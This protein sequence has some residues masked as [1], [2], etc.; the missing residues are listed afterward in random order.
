MDDLEASKAYIEANIDLVPS[1]L[2]LRALTAQKL[3]AQSKNDL[4]RMDYLKE[5]RRRYILANDQLFFPLNLEVRTRARRQA[6]AGGS[7]F[8]EYDGCVHSSPLTVLSFIRSL[9]HVAVCFHGG[10]QVQKA[11]TRVMT[12]L[13]RQ[14][15][16]SWGA[17][18]DEVE[19]SLHAV[20]LLAARLT[21]DKRVRVLLEDIQRKVG[22]CLLSYLGPYIIPI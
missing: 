4:A 9:T 17:Q 8:A 3:S 13:A 6:G 10:G 11:E 2:F 21:W 19:M 12:F 5:V 1:V 7:T 15:L 20:T 14:E 18:W 16:R 22:G